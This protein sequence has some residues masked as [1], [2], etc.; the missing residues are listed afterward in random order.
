MKIFILSPNKDNLDN[1]LWEKCN[2]YGI[3]TIREQD[4]ISARNYAAH[5][6]NIDPDNKKPNFQSPWLVENL[7]S[8]D[9]FQGDLYSLDGA[10]GILHP[11]SLRDA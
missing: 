2:F 1:K 8:C 11:A 6:F 7:V 4:K 3:V 5:F 10:P 9:E